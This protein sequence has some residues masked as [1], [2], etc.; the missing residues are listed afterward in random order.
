MFLTFSLQ[1]FGV[2]EDE[3]VQEP[4]EGEVLQRVTGV[5]DGPSLW[6]RHRLTHSRRTEEERKRKLCVSA[7]GVMFYL[8]ESLGEQRHGRV[9]VQRELQTQTFDQFRRFLSSIGSSCSSEYHQ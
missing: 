8:Q 3:P 1:L 2:S 4:D 7:S 6:K 9:E 5:L